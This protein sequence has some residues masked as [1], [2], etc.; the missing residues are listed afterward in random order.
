[1]FQYA[2]ARQRELLHGERVLYDLYFFRSLDRARKLESVPHLHLY[3]AD[4]NVRLPKVSVLGALFYRLLGRYYSGYPHG[5][6][7]E[8]RPQLLKEF[9]LRT[10]PPPIVK[11]IRATKNSVAVHIR[12][13]DY[14]GNKNFDIIGLD[15]FIDAAKYM[16]KKLGT[17]TFFVFSDDL[18]WV[19]ENLDLTKFGKVFFMDNNSPNQDIIISAACE[20][21]I[22][23][24]STFAWWCA[25]LNQNPGKIV[26][27][28]RR[29]NASEHLDIESSSMNLA[30]WI[31]M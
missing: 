12:R 15:Y 5:E 16:K 4:F 23:T 7:R 9:T 28:P 10:M 26:V 11:K 18:N 19:R 1:M 6:F 22:I 31:L 29:W 14:V 17:P 3:L 27:S 13:G 30:E 20:N 24:N 8:I 2:Y 25:W 21:H